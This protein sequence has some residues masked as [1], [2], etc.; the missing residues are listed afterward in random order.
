MAHRPSFGVGVVAY[1]ASKLLIG[2][3]EAAGMAW[4][5]GGGVEIS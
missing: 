4:P 3:G 2:A 5:V 1:I